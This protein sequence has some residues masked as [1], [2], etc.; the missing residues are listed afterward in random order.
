MHVISSFCM[1]VSGASEGCKTWK[2]GG[3]TILQSKIG[4]CIL[5]PTG[6]K[7]WGW[8]SPCPPI[9]TRQ[10]QPQFSTTKYRCSFGCTYSSRIQAMLSHNKCYNY[11]TMSAWLRYQE[12]LARCDLAE[13]T[14]L[15]LWLCLTWHG[16]LA[17]ELPFFTVQ[18]TFD[19]M[20]ALRIWVPSG[21]SCP[22]PTCICFTLHI[23]HILF[24]DVT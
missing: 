23:L 1:G 15:A 18:V 5:L 24:I 2:G 22:V 10:I 21:F 9:L 14:I 17:F 13:R 4:G 3:C 19:V 16:T 8:L 6:L 11:W 7:V 20:L 12:V